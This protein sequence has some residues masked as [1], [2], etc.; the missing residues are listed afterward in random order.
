MYNDDDDPEE[1]NVAKNKDDK[2]PSFVTLK[3]LGL[4]KFT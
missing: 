4:F 2:G 1:N 3:F